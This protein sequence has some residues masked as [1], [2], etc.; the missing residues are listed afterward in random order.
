MALTGAASEACGF[1]TTEVAACAEAP[2]VVGVDFF[3]SSAFTGAMAPP[4][5]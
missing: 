5:L 4:G 1:C 3:G 2:S